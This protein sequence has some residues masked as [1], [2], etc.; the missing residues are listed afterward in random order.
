MAAAALAV[1]GLAGAAPAARAQ[2]QADIPTV[3]M[4]VGGIDKQIYLP[5]QLAEGLGF[6]KKYGVN[7]VL[8]TETEG[9][10]GAEDAMV[11]GQVDMAGA[12]YV[13]TIDFQLHGKAV[14]DVAQLSAS[15]GEREMCAK[16]THIASPADWRGKAVGVTDIGS[17]TDDLTLYLAMRSGLGPRDF[18]RISA[19]AGQ[20]LIAALKYGKIVCGMTIQPTV[21]AIEKLGVGYSAID[22]TTARG[23]RQW[24][25]GDW[26]TAAVLAR[27]DWVEKHKEAT[28]RVVNAIVATMH[29]IATHSAADIADHMP[30]DFVQNPL[31]SR[32][33]YVAALTQDK[34]QFLPD[35]MMPADG[36]ATVQA[37]EKLAGKISGPVDVPA[38][39]TNAFAA[40]ANKAEGFTK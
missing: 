8:S 13:H 16:G 7:M 17:G 35:G 12:W 2:N 4:M 10:V 37:V 25:G 34:A 21:N 38:T 31:S 22:L 26:P 18:S 29:Y 15:P 20:T 9:G 28:Q 5:Y 14:I 1:A 30:A 19:G 23:V 40:E 11:S 36:P 6:Y 33:E 24:L 3:T 32:G 27:T 39:Y